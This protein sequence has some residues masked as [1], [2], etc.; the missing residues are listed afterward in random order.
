EPRKFVLKDNT[1]TNDWG[2][3]WRVPI[4]N[5]IL[6][7]ELQS[8]KWQARKLRIISAKYCIIKKSLYKRG[9]SD[10]YLLCIF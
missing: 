3:D 10:P 1:S 9:I 2:A 6:N 5:F 8:N 7:G 4:K